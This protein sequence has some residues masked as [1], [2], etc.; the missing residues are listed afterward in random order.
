MYGL[1]GYEAEQG[2]TAAQN[3]GGTPAA[4]FAPYGGRPALGHMGPVASKFIQSWIK[5]PNQFQY[6]IEVFI[7]NYY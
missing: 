4:G 7:K 5:A 2:I 3:A 6:W 1:L